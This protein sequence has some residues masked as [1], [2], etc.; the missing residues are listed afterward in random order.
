M[1]LAFAVAALAFAAAP[2][3]VEEARSGKD[4][5][6]TRV[7]A[8]AAGL[9][10]GCDL[11]DGGA[12]AGA[13]AAE[14]LDGARSAA[15]AAAPPETRPASA[16]ETPYKEV[17]APAP[18]AAPAKTSPANPLARVLEGTRNLAHRVKITIRRIFDGARNL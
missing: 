3:R 7:A 18:A 9:A 1:R 15:P 14:A 6:E 8:V 10:Q 11:F 2:V 5:V 4:D 16:G 13:D 17:A 12:G